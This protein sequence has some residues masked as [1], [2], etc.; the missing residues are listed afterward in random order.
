M[1]QKEIRP[2]GNGTDTRSITTSS[3][4]ERWKLCTQHGGTTERRS[5][6]KVCQSQYKRQWYRNNRDRVLAQQRQYRAANLGVV[7]AKHHRERARRYGLILIT[8]LITPED[9]IRRWGDRCIYCETGAFEEIDHIIPVR[10]GGHHQLWN[11]VPCCRACNIKKR[12]SIDFLLI[13]WFHDINGRD[14]DNGP[15]DAAYRT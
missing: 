7:W 5:G 12:W 2:A 3:S 10:V 4:S 8:D 1:S 13:R 6:C 9:V 11:V 14:A 15:S